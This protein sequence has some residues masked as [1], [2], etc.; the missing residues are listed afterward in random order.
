MADN[1]AR[2]FAAAIAPDPARPLLTWYDD[3]TGERTE[4]SGATLANWVAKTANL[5]ADE[6]AAGP[7][8]SA[9]V[10]LPPHWQ[11]AAV[12]L[13]CWSAGLVVADTPGPVEVLFAAAD[14]VA[15]A[16]A[17]P[18]GERYAFALAPFALP[19]RE[20]PAGFADY[21]VAVRVHGDHFTPYAQVGPADAELLARATARATELGLARG[22]RVMLDVTAH[23]DPVDWLLAPLV[24]GASTVLCANPDPARLP[25]RAETERVTRALT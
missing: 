12:L 22:D 3:A 19:L 21:V 13:G 2:V 7:G 23:P 10:L 1:I 24:A 25:G 14:R 11:T 8:E 17:W 20:V 4:L 5:L 18:A 6:A 15:E 9:G 16:D